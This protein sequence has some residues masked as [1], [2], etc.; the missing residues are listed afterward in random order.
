MKNLSIPP[1][2]EDTEIAVLGS[3]VIE[4]QLIER[5]SDLL[6]PKDFYKTANQK[7]Y[8]AM[9]EMS[10][11]NIAID[12]L[13]LNNYLKSKGNLDDVGG[14]IYLT[15]LEELCP[16]SANYK[17]YAK[18]VKEVSR[19]RKISILTQ[20][21]R[22]DIDNGTV[23]L[24][25][26]EGAICEFSDDISKED[27][28]S[29]II[30]LS[31]EPVPEKRKWIIEDFIPM[32]FPTTLYSTG[33]VGKSY[34]AIYL[35]INISLGNKEFL[36][37][38]FHNE[39][40]NTLYL[41]F[42]LDKDELTR[43]AYEI[44]RGIGRDSIPD[45]FYY[46]SPESRI[47]NL[48]LKLPSFIKNNDIRF[49]VIDSM[50]AAGLDS[51]DEKS[52]I[53]V[54]S[55]LGELGSTTTLV[56]DHQSKMQSKDNPE[57][58]SPFGSVYKY[59]MSRSVI[60]LVHEKNIENG[61]TV[62]FVHKKNNL[63]KKQDEEL[64]DLVFDGNKVYVNESQSISQ[65]EEEM[66]SIKDA[67]IEMLQDQTQ[68]NQIDLIK[69][70][71]NTIPKNRLKKLL[72]KGESKYWNKVKGN[73]KNS[74]NYIPINYIPINDTNNLKIQKTQK[75]DYIYNGNSGFLESEIPDEP[76][77]LQLT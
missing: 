15:R 19:L 41:D 4:G 35:A 20:Q 23:G 13:T 39:P 5:I 76:E 60:H 3:I 57:N 75:S 44:T 26:I 66:L 71:S 64:I 61:F 56:I 27:S 65:Q 24:S 70:F 48:L 9:L 6:Q 46:K 77:S 21:L 58:K 11:Q 31:D 45:N 17:H 40:L 25:K 22:Q 33:G 67:I 1:R 16:S 8:K 2:N 47:S 7:I 28:Y 43:R 49:L 54:Y 62:K 73:T 68:V 29:G 32:G 69:Y 37:R 59:N 55:K 51:M 72:G 14:A 38:K 36:N 18:T 52:V 63:G 53:E 30:R 12:I 42:E 74:V 10:K 50:G 34:L